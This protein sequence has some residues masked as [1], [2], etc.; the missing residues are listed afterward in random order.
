VTKPAARGKR[1][2]GDFVCAILLAS[3]LAVGIV[4][5]RAG[6]RTE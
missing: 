1:A 6:E 3:G 4:G 2:P 5:F